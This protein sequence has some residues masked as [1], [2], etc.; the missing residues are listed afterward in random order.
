MSIAKESYC[1]SMLLV[2]SKDGERIYQKLGFKVSSYYEFYKNKS[3][4]NFKISEKVSKTS[5]SDY[6]NINKLDKKISGEERSDFLKIHFNN[7]FVFRN[8]SDNVE[9]FYL[10]DCGR[11]LVIAENNK[12][13]IELLKLRSNE[14][15]FN[16]V[17]REQNKSAKSFLLENGFELYNKAPR[18]YFGCEVNWEPGMVFSRGS[19]YAG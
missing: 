17:I 16:N 3:V 14:N 13:G 12:A 4:S 8:I 18:M 1:K 2:A 11:G 15:K 19:G 7:S 5:P 10:P 9:G 6:P